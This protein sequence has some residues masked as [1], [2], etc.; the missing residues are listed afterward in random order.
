MTA[1]EN[2]M[3][4]IIYSNP[5]G[6]ERFKNRG[7]CFLDF[8]D[9]K[10]ASD[11]KRKI[12]MGK[13]KP[14]NH[15]LV[16]DWAEPQDEP[17]EETMSQVKVLY[18][19]NLKEAVTEE[20]LT[21][22]FGQHGEIERVKKIK[23]YAFVHFKEREGAIKALEALR[24]TVLEDIQIDISLAKPQSDKKKKT[25]MRGRGVFGN[26]R[27]VGGRGGGSY[28]GNDYGGVYTPPLAATGGGYHR[29]GGGRYPPAAPAYNNPY[30]GAGGPLGYEPYGNYG[31]GGAYGGGG[32]YGGGYDPYSAYAPSYSAPVNAQVA[33]FIV[34][35]NKS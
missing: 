24:G 33:I 35:Y 25:G 1:L 22:L 7:F 10:S 8:G 13:V 3:D 29:G 30:P 4:V 19:K 5:E 14:W 9:H 2:V 34:Y 6:G 16:V 28:G 15:D 31:G 20:R 12:S 17:D 26:T 18:V 32:G 21:E 23:D 11:A 27:G